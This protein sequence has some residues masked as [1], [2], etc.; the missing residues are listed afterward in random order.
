MHKNMHESRSL[1]FARF[2]YHDVDKPRLSR[3]VLLPHNV[4][5]NTKLYFKNQL[6]FFLLPKNLQPKIMNTP[7][8]VIP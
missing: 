2:L 3:R 4:R 7:K 1:R 5:N 6:F 8:A